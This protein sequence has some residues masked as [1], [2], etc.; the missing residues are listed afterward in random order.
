MHKAIQHKTKVDRDFARDVHNGLSSEAKYL[1]SKYFY[2]AAGDKLFQQIMH[3][4]EYYLTRVEYE[5]FH[6][7]SDAIVNSIRGLQPLQLIELGAGDGT[8]TKLQLQ[9]RIWDNERMY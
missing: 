8:K 3:L 9:D 2:D 6:D 5:I 1:S 4:P 7:Q